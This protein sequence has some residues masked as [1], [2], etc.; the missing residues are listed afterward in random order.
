M[1]ASGTVACD[2]WAYGRSQAAAS[3][4]MSRPSPP[5]SEKCVKNWISN[6]EMLAFGLLIIEGL[7]REF[8]ATL[9]DTSSLEGFFQRTRPRHFIYRRVSCRNGG[10]S[11]K[12]IWTHTWLP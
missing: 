7:S 3:K 2:N 12:R 10:S 9:S 8:V 1:S 11:R 6:C 5:A 4:L